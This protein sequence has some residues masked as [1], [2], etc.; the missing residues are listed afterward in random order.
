LTHGATILADT[1]KFAPLYYLNRVEGVRPDVKP[2][3]LGDEAAYRRE[4][5]ARVGQGQP[6][7]LARFLPNLADSF[8]LRSVGPLV[9][10]A[11][12]PLVQPPTIEHTQPLAVSHQPPIELLGYN[13][14][15]ST[16]PIR[17]TLFWRAKDRID[18]NYHVHVRLVG[19]SGHVW[20]EESNHPVTGEY[21][22][23]AWRP[24]EIVPDYHE[25]A[26][27]EFFPPGT[28]C[29]EVG[30]SRPFSSPSDYLTLTEV[31]VGSGHYQADPPHA[32]RA[33]FADELMLVGYDA[34]GMLAPDTRG[35]L[36]LFWQKIRPSD[37]AYDIAIAMLDHAGQMVTSYNAQPFFGEYPTSRWPIGGLV[38]T[39]HEIAMP[40]GANEVTLR[41]GLRR[42]GGDF[43]PVT[44]GWLAT[45]DQ[46]VPLPSIR[47]SESVQVAIANFDDRIALEGYELARRDSSL[48]IT[49]TWRCLRRM[50]EDYTLFVHV[51]DANQK[52][53][54]QIDTW[55]RD[56]TYPTSRW[57]E[58]ET[59]RERYVV[60]ISA[61]AP[62]GEYQVEV[63]WYLLAT[64][65]RL[66]VLGAN[67]MP[68]DDRLLIPGIEVH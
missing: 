59:I 2:I 61:Q 7:Y 40:A 6:V 29:I 12:M 30:L 36:T 4:V 54:G 18:G 53:W 57:K 68:I 8:H 66:P 60:P 15:A 17:L 26:A 20:L 27:G 9:E 41:V 38:A 52:L 39:R 64:M 50:D 43:L 16:D 19:S 21:P 22:T 63:G 48:E 65:R 58:G 67:G 28:Y 46:W 51:L 42:T 25:L 32:M 62:P 55:P 1:E 56:G 35:T 37:A 14:D 47:A 34:P 44:N 33:N 11:K 23:S 24:G 13:V 10:V 31:Q 3:L 45:T 5:D 49:L